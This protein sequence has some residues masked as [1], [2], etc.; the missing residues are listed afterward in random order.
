[1]FAVSAT[2]PRTSPIRL[3]L[4]RADQIAS[5]GV[6][7]ITKNH[8]DPRVKRTAQ[9][10][11]WIHCAPRHG[12][13]AACTPIPLSFVMVNCQ[14]SCLRCQVKLAPKLWANPFH[15]AKEEF[16]QLLS[17]S[18]VSQTPRPI[19]V[20]ESATAAR[21]QPG[22]TVRLFRIVPESVGNCNLNSQ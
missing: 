2:M 20:S 8:W 15:S 4:R 9:A 12:T 14:V 3:P 7:S 10:R 11:L 6:F 21:P 19:H 16:W 18:R 22:K 17:T 5:I 1:M 13:Y